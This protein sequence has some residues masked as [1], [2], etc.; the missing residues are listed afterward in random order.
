VRLL[1]WRIWPL[2]DSAE[3]SPILHGIHGLN[4]TEFVVE[5]GGLVEE[6]WGVIGYE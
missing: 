2:H 3:L 5:V 1:H 4:M 6:G